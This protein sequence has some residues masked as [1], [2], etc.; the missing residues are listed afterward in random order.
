MKLELGVVVLNN[1]ITIFQAKKPSPDNTITL[2]PG[3]L[4][5]INFVCKYLGETELNFSHL[6][7]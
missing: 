3:I 5:Y 1:E 7:S 2:T 4:I 6:Q